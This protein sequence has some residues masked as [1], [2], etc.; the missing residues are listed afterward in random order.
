MTENTRIE[1]P[2][3]PVRARLPDR[4]TSRLYDLALAKWIVT[5]DVGFDR[6]GGRPLEVFLD[7]AKRNFDHPDGGGFTAL[8][9]RSSGFDV[10]AMLND[11]AVAISV[12]LQY[13][14][15]PAALAK[16]M[17]RVPAPALAI[18]RSIDPGA[19]DQPDSQGPRLPASVVGAVLDLL[20]EA[21]GEGAGR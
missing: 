13:G 3:A 11:F 12:A 19:L 8:L 1:R 4:R 16:S 5:V 6:P 9:A 20:V 18:G 17:G 21:A 7:R 14:I 2:A 10:P 15:P